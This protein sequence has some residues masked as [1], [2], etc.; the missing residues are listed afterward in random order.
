MPPIKKISIG[1]MFLILISCYNSLDI[2]QLDDLAI[3][4]VFTSS[5]TYFTVT[6]AQFFSASGVQIN[7]DDFSAFEIFE[8]NLV[9]ENVIKIDFN[10]EIRN[11]FDRKVTIII[12]FLDDNNKLTYSS[13]TIVIEANVNLHTYLEEI[14]VNNNPNIIN[15]S[16]VRI[17]AALEDTGIPL[18]AN[19]TSEFEFKSSITLHMEST[20]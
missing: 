19:D 16:Q 2:D 18:N 9:R 3:K 1:L 17:N 14:I 4:P 8:N 13:T 6:Q 10:A 15:T 7:I 12:D 11:E 20:L 5:L